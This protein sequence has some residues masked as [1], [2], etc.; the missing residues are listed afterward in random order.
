MPDS[1]KRVVE[2]FEATLVF[3]I[4]EDFP[5]VWSTVITDLLQITE[6]PDSRVRSLSLLFRA[7]DLTVRAPDRLEEDEDGHDVLREK[8]YALGKYADQIFTLLSSLWASSH[9]DILVYFEKVIQSG[10]SDD[11]PLFSANCCKS[12]LS[13]I[14]L[15][16][17]HYY[18]LL[19]AS[20]V[21]GFLQHLASVLEM[22][23]KCKLQLGTHNQSNRIVPFLD[24]SIKR[25]LKLLIDAV[26]HFPLRIICYAE[27]FLR[28]S[29][30]EINVGFNTEDEFWSKYIINHMYFVAEILEIQEFSTF[31]DEEEG[32]D[33]YTKPKDLTFDE[34]IRLGREMC[35]KYFSDQ[36]LLLIFH[37]IASRYMLLSN[38]Q[39]TLWEEEPEEILIDTFTEAYSYNIAPASEFLLKRMLR[40]SETF[41]SAVAHVLE[42]DLQKCWQKPIKEIMENPTVLALD[43]LYNILSIFGDLMDATTANFKAVYVD[44]L[45]KNYSS[46]LPKYIKRRVCQIIQTWSDAIYNNKLELSA[47][48][49]LHDCFVEKDLVTRVYATLAFKSMLN[50]FDYQKPQCEK[51]LAPSIA[52]IIDLIGSINSSQAT[53]FMLKLVAAIIMKV[54]EAIRPHT[55]GIL[56]K[57][58]LLWEDSKRKNNSYLMAGVIQIV[59]NL[60]VALVGSAIEMEPVYA[61]ML[62]STLN[63]N[64]FDMQKGYLVVEESMIMWYNCVQ[65]APFLTP[66]VSYFF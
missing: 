57:A 47:L 8:R 10:S 39:L 49:I 24:A 40:H 34:S 48:E 20:T 16:F 4:H 7:I 6:N 65:Q 25:I 60:V 58:S 14:R 31:K 51:Y 11:A 36:Q 55:Q 37:S 52:S 29:I 33:N 50:N 28:L 15:L 1:E 62:L 41:Q 54:R 61:P 43:S 38:E 12:S 23:A 2:T 66:Q 9:N 13:S 35:R 19:N 46:F 44:I 64:R 56:D 18:S 30:E 17:S 53:V 45:Y 59:T 32:Y 26:H 27:P 5:D 22:S 21:G 63:M 42:G 3:I